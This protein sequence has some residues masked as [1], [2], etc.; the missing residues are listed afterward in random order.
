MKRFFLIFLIFST[1]SSSA[2]I[3]VACV[4]NSVTYGANIENRE[5]NSYPAQLQSMLGVGYG[6]TNYGRS[7]ATLLSNG[8]NPYIQTE[9][10]SA[11]IASKSDI[12]VI[13]LGL[14][15]T[16][17]RNYARYREQ[18]KGD[19]ISLINSFR[20]ANPQAS[21]IIARMSP[22]THYHYRFKAGTR[23]WYAAIQTEIEAVAAATG[24]KLID[25]EAPLFTRPDLLPDALH[26]TAQG[27]TLLAQV[28]YGAIT[29]NFGGLK[30]GPLYGDNMVLQMGTKT[31]IAGIA[32]AGKRVEVA[33]DGSS[34]AATAADNG[35]WEVEVNLPTPKT[36][37]EL[38]V[39]SDGVEKRFKNVAVGQVWILSGQSNMSLP[40]NDCTTPENAKPKADIRLFKMTPTFESHKVL[41]PEEL[42]A[43]NNLDFIGAK[44]W[45][46]AVA[47]EIGGFSAIG[48]YFAQMVTDSIGIPVG[49]VQT[50]LGGAPAEAFVSRDRLQN[51]PWLDDIL[52][53]P[54]DNQM[55]D[56]WV[57][58]VMKNSLKDSKSLSQRHYFEPAYLYESR[59]LPIKGF[60]ANGVLWYQGESNA[61]KAELHSEL[62]P[63]VV[64]SFREVFDNEKLPFYFVQL[65]DCNRPSWPHFRQTQKELA[66]Q[67]PNCKMVVSMDYGD[68]N[69][70]HPRR[71]Q[72][73]GERLAKLAIEQ[74]AADN[75]V[76]YVDA[77]SLP[78]YGKGDWPTAS[79]YERLPLSIKGTI[80]PD[81]WYLGTNS[82]GMYI[83]FRTNSKFIRA[84]WQVTNNNSMPHMA[85]VGT[86]GLDLYSISGGEWQFVGSTGYNYNEAQMIGGMDGKMS[87][88]MLYLPLYD[89][90]K[91]LKIGVEPN[92]VIE[93]PQLNSPRAENPILFYGTSITQGACA[94]RPAMSYSSIVSRRLNRSAINLGFS[95][96][97]KLD[98][99]IASI[100]AQIKNPSCFVLDF[101]PNCSADLIRENMW[102]FIAILRSKHPNVPIVIVENY[103]YPAA[104]VSQTAAAEI[105]GKNRMLKAQFEKLRKAGDKNIYYVPSKNII[106]VDGEATVDGVHATDLGFMRWADAITPILE[107]I[108]P[109]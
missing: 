22:I 11:A 73:I 2:Q 63:Q 6:V 79:R 51:N 26:P 109:K 104:M 61:D 32:N 86:R 46:E 96:N 19:Y 33:I 57:R 31:R 106:G 1:F 38:V 108:I 94:S 100:M 102:Q 81:L 29:G 54:A 37:L 77:D 99:P 67:I 107:K 91:S 7:G 65:A 72:P 101:V 88:Y 18:F 17:P 84:R 8:H 60:A 58:S 80:R 85:D 62:F 4:G 14:N 83:R 27:A 34:Y 70:V 71:K 76:K 52:Y 43:V 75:S 56:E 10:Y 78:L 47:S 9:L 13:H 28:V 69:D 16:D 90:L 50:S 53:S 15:D 48:Y 41:T 20:E 24:V 25:F 74:Y 55:I 39:S 36:G 21:I 49:L 95:G 30:M 68:V 103:L 64:A 12:V 42:T 97:G 44:G 93:Y 87:E 5:L 92:A 82:S 3:K 23:I 45:S 35:M 66:S 59:I 98:L 89:N 105:D 40:V